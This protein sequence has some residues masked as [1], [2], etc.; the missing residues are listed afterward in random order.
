MGLGSDV[1]GVFRQIIQSGFGL[2]GRVR[3]RAGLRVRMRVRVRVRVRIRV[4]VRVRVRVR[5]CQ[6][7]AYLYDHAIMA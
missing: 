5:T 7:L 1:Q 3:L 2:G 4:G 6:G